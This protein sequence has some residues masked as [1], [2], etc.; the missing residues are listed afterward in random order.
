VE[1]ASRTPPWLKLS[2]SSP[3]RILPLDK[4]RTTISASSMRFDWT[5]RKIKSVS[6]S[7]TAIRETI[8]LVRTKAR[9]WI[10]SNVEKASEDPLTIS[11]VGDLEIRLHAAEALLQRAARFL[12]EAEEIPTETTVAKVSTAVAEAKVV[13]TE[14]AILATNKLFELAGTQSTL[15]K[16]NLDRHW[17]NARTHTL[18]DPVRW[19]Y[20]AIGNYYLNNVNPP[21][22]PGN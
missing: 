16:Y 11:Q 18:H 21:R 22:H 1:P 9:P 4:S 8:E 17:R 19:K 5:E 13:T 3:R 12:D 20:Y 6:I 10:D 14:I 15:G 7:N 2:L